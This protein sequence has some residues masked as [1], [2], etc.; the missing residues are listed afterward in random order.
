ME[1]SENNNGQKALYQYNENVETRWASFEN[2][3]SEKGQGGKAGNGAKG[4]PYH[5]L[6]KGE[7]VTIL[8]VDG[9]G[10]IHRIWMTVDKLFYIP[11]EARSIRID[12]YWD[13]SKKPAVSAPLEDFF[14]QTFG[15]MRPFDSELFSSPEGRSLV[16]FVP[17]PF[18]KGAKITLTN[19]SPKRNHRIFYDINFSKLNKAADD[20]LYFHA[21]WRR[22]NLTKLGR[23]FEILPKVEGKGRFLGTNIGVIANSQYEGWWG[24][25]EVKVYLDG[26]KQYPTLVGTGTEDY[27]ASGFSQAEFS[28]RYSGCLIADSEKNIFSLYR[29]H[30]PDPVWFHKDIRVTI[31]QMGGGAKH[32]VKKM[33]SRGLAVEPVCYI[34]KGNEQLNFSDKQYSFEDDSYPKD[35]WTNYYREDDVCATAWFYLDN[36][37]NELP[38]LPSFAERR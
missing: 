21:H 36:P 17:M 11:E 10:I 4:Y 23:D 38:A 31:Q 33:I 16:C 22:E 15:K 18:K 30:V 37:E 19:E 12:M 27:I 29:Y 25:G 20:M 14:N 13:G 5:L 34:N 7:T 1:Q 8:E 26:D 24:E 6:Q 28:T 3:K 9:P 35:I 2:L 32:L